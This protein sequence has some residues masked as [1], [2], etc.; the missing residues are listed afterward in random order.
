MLPFPF[1]GSHVLIE[2]HPISTLAY[3]ANPNFASPKVGADA[4]I[5][6]RMPYTSIERKSTD[7]ILTPSPNDTVLL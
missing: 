4:K 2:I 3:P 1:Y 6:V 7:L 5:G